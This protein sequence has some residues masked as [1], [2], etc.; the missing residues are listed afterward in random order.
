MFSL[1]ITSI[2]SNTYINKWSNY[3]LMVKAV[4]V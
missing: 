4:M 2:G 1:Q 3:I